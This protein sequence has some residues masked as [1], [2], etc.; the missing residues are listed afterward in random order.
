MALPNLW[1]TLQPGALTAGPQTRCLGICVVVRQI[2]VVPPLLSSITQGE[3][4]R[5]KN[6][7]VRS[8]LRPLA[9]HTPS[10]GRCG[11]GAGV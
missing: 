3:V 5:G 7:T 4:H 2:S 11:Q 9:T 1:Q 6:E 8:Q 10:L